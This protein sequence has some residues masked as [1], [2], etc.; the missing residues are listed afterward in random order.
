MSVA[1]LTISGR[2][3]QQFQ[4]G[5]FREA[6]SGWQVQRGNSMGGAQALEGWVLSH[7]GPCVRGSQKYTAQ[8]ISTMHSCPTQRHRQTRQKQGLPPV[9]TK[10]NQDQYLFI[11][12]VFRKT[13]N[14]Q[15]FTIKTILIHVNLQRYTILNTKNWNLSFDNQ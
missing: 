2:Q 10:T 13:H 3:F 1:I 15:Q 9:K 6:I 5:N 8:C 12:L 14:L 7:R 4:G 11:Q